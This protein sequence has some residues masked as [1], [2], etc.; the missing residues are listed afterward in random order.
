MQKKKEVTFL[1]LNEQELMTD[2]MYIKVCIKKRTRYVVVLFIKVGS[3][4]FL[5]CGA[6]VVR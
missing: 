2:E 6:G 5:F 3:K 1:T 4:I